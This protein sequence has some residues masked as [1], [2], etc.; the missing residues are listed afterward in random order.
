MDIT[1]RR[2]ANALVFHTDPKRLLEADRIIT[3][4]LKARIPELTTLEE[5]LKRQQRDLTTEE[6]SMFVERM[7]T[8]ETTMDIMSEIQKAAPELHQALVGERDLF[9][10]RGLDVLFSSSLSAILPPK[11]LS[12]KTP[13]SLQ[14]CVA[15]I[16]LGHVAGVGRELKSLGWQKFTPSGC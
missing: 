12:G 3:S 8:K 14:T 11:A 5:E 15:V 9:M 4:K 13:T 7:K 1:M 2:L 16:G 10:A 6:L